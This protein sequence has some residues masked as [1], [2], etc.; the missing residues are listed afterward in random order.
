MTLLNLAACGAAWTIADPT[1]GDDTGVASAAASD[2]AP[3]GICVNEVMPANDAAVADETGAF[4][5][6]IELFNPTATPVS[7]GDWTL[8]NDAEETGYP[9][10]A[11]V[12]VPAF[13]YRLLWADEAPTLG[14]YHLP[15]SLDADG[16]E[17]VLRAPDGSAAVLR[18]GEVAADFSVARIPDCCDPDDC[19]DFVWRGTPGTTNGQ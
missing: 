18:W 13:G 15:F 12:T 19:L 7:L 9:M 17:A 2:R 16:G 3:V 5:D 8:G 14:P 11:A 6:W 4:P 10:D 1:P